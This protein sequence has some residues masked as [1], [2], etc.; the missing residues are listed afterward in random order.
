MVHAATASPCV[1]ARIERPA[2]DVV[3]EWRF[4]EIE[5]AGV[6][7]VEALRL[8]LDLTFDVARLRDLVRHGCD[9]ALAVSILA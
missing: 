4:D 7:M 3:V 9:A 6:D 2:P 8:A 1:R 5:R